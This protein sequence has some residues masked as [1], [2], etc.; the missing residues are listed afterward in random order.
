MVVFCD[1]QIPFLSELLKQKV[2]VVL[3]SGRKLSNKELIKSNCEALFVRSTTKVNSNLLQQTNIKFVGTATS[4]IDHIDVDY[5][6]SMDIY[7]VDAKGSNANSVAE[8]VVFS[9]LHW[10]CT[11]QV[12]LSGSTFGI[13]G[14]GN[15]GK[16]VAKYSNYL[17]LKVLIN[18]PPLKELIERGLAE[19]FPDY[20]EYC[21]FPEIIKYSNIISNHVPLTFSGKYP[22]YYLFNE[23]NLS[24]LQEGTLFIHT[25]RGGVVKEKSLIKLKF[26]KNLS[27]VVDVWEN[28]PQINLN[29]LKTC[30]IATPH[31][32]GYSFD[33]KLRGAKKLIDEFQKFFGIKIDTSVLEQELSRYTPAEKPFFST[34]SKLYQQLKE[35]RQI[36]DDF[37][38]LKK[39]LE[40]DDPS[41]KSKYFDFLR[42]SYPIRRET[43]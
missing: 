38:K 36:L 7:F 16:I 13:I 21:E 20:C 32:A 40:I 29:L 33:G 8:Y 26:D 19:K 25:S 9:I 35:S 24:L 12:E 1:E 11:N 6:K 37:E 42:K 27:L 22:T 31:I 5:L 17:G 23:N 14:F 43:L 15:I 30:L 41:E 2:D 39:I 34:P 4:G 10:H 18:D 28:E 3:F